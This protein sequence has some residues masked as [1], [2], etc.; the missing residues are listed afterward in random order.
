M[1]ELQDTSCDHSATEA[2]RIAAYPAPLSPADP[3]P[4]I[5]VC[6]SGLVHS[7]A[8]TQQ[9]VDAHVIKTLYRKYGISMVH[10][11]YGEFALVICDLPAKQ[12]YL[13]RDHIGTQPLYWAQ[14]RG[15]VWFSSSMP[16]LIIESEIEA[17][18]DEIRVMQYL[19]SPNSYPDRSFYKNIHLV[20][21]GHWVRITSKDLQKRRWWDPRKINEQ[22]NISVKDVKATVRE[23]TLS[24][25]EARLPSDA[26][27]GSH[28][29]GGIDSTIV[30]DLSVAALKKRAQKLH[31]AYTWSPAI[32]PPYPSLGPRDERHLILDQAKQWNLPIKFGQTTR[33]HIE[34]LIAHPLEHHGTADV[35]DELA[36]I[37]QA[38]RD[39]IEVML[40]G[41]GG[42]ELFSSHGIG[43]QAWM[44]SHGYWRPLLGYLR[45]RFGL[46]HPVMIAK[47]LGKSAIIPWLPDRLYHSLSPFTEV[48]KNGAFLS[49]SMQQLACES[50]GPPQPRLFPDAKAYAC[51][52][53][54][55]GHLAERM[56]SWHAWAQPAGLE[57]RYP[58]VDRALMEFL[59]SVPREILFGNG[60]PR[61]LV[62]R[63]F[64]DRLPPG[65]NKYDLANEKRR[66]DDRLAWWRAL[67]VD[68]VNGRF[69]QD[70][71]WLDMKELKG[72]I[73]HG[74]S[75]NKLEDISQIAKIFV[76][77]RVY[78]MYWRMK[79]QHF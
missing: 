22:P 68:D 16:Q 43:H 76:A 31:A 75:G 3:S 70:C 15:K 32:K 44:L 52:M 41:W 39:G 78:S 48:Y 69:A 29:S 33:H 51:Q 6:L 11:L 60:Q 49:K 35:M 25:V 36:T 64:N 37:E 19:S 5:K 56:V 59:L 12:I 27:V 53:I 62:R 61:L 9:P 58:L 74:P 8:L 46:R 47:W 57:Y 73:R 20:L 66:H 7:S 14:S 17:E 77:L 67:Q 2:C 79:K 65:L 40:S 1:L 30:T 18:P 28:M 10:S 38:S 55:H 63:A 34:Q 45:R 24:A 13:V 50:L 54:M 4:E 72:A 42:D 21:P 23:L 71:P 26:R